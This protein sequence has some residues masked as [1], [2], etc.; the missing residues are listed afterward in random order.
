MA[1]TKR[2]GQANVLTPT[3]VKDALAALETNPRGR[4]MFLLSVKA[5]LRSV[6]IAGLQWGDLD[7]ANRNIIL[8]DTKGDGD[9]RTLPMSDA[10]LHALTE[11]KQRGPYVFRNKHADP[12]ARLDRNT[13]AVWFGDFYRRRMGWVGY[14][15]HSGRRTFCTTLARKIVSDGGSLEDVRGAMGHA[16][17]KTTSRYIERNPDALRKAMEKM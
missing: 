9:A 11:M 2:T 7:F 16:D 8:R 5:G 4:A 10:V 1:R 14:S 6:E 12:S 13:V 15:S 17:L 3:N